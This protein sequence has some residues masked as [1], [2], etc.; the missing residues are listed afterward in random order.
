MAEEE[1]KESILDIFM[2]PLKSIRDL[3]SGGEGEEGGATKSIGERLDSIRETLGLKDLDEKIK[4]VMKELE[5]SK[6]V[7]KFKNVMEI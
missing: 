5:V 4:A 2:A 3:I 6:R 7:E 1:K